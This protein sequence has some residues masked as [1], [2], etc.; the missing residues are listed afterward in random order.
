MLKRFGQ[1]LAIVVLAFLVASGSQAAAFSLVM[2]PPRGQ[3]VTN[4]SQLGLSPLAANADGSFTVT[5]SQSV[6]SLLNAG[7]LVS[8]NPSCVVTATLAAGTATISSFPAM[9]PAITAANI[10]V[11]G[12]YGATTP[13]AV[14]GVAGSGSLVLHSASGT[15]TST[16]VCEL[17]K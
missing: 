6:R 7:W 13:N 1:A 5:D 11:C 2:R 17:E 15:D 14:D 4:L 3:S 9:C 12:E 16:T 8:A 10:F